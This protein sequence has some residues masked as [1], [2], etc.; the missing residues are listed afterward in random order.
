MGTQNFIRYIGLSDI[1]ESDIY[2]G[3]SIVLYYGDRKSYPIYT[4]IRYNR[5]R[6][7]RVLLY[8]RLEDLAS[9]DHTLI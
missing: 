5:V 7:I 1:T 9:S 2:E 4:V 6:Y 8:H 3:T